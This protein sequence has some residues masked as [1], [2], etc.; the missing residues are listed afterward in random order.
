MTTAGPSRWRTFSV[1]CL[2]GLMVISDG[3]VVTVALASIKLDLAFSDV[4]LVWV[5]NAYLLTFSGFVLLGG[6]LADIFGQR[7]LFLLG[8][9]LFTAASAACGLADTRALLI[10]ARAVQGLGGAIVSSVSLSLTLS[11]FTQAPERAKAMGIYT[12]VSL[13]AGAF[14]LFVG[15]TLTSALG[16]R[17]IFWVN[18]PLGAAIYPFCRAS[19]PRQRDRRPTGKVDIAGAMVVT[20]S[21]VLAVYASINA[22]DAGW[23]SVQTLTLLAS[24][25][26]LLMLFLHIESRASAPLVPLGLLR[27]RNLVVGGAISMLWAFTV[28]GWCLVAAFYLQVVLKCNPEQVGLAFLPSNLSAAAISLGLSAR[29]VARFGIKR[30]LSIGLLLTAGALALLARAP[31]GG[32]VVIDV[33][34]AMLLDGIG[35]G[36]VFS[37][38]L[39]AATS[40]TLPAESGLVAGVVNTAG[41]ISSTL[42]L[43]I[44]V[45]T[46]AAHTRDLVT[47]GASLPA[48]L[49]SGYHRA[50]S[51]GAILLIVASLMTRLLRIE[52]H[53]MAHVV[54]IAVQ[55]SS[56]SI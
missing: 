30:T 56:A 26:G 39:L 19:L 34:P 55:D 17:W 12:F 1:L 2:A 54:D 33:L 13:F 35:S 36:L 44:L 22:N 45:A 11:L 14:G 51:I 15:G 21:S 9:S 52:Q 50:F 28:G 40:G 18:L 8:I 23:S 47:I 4:T 10:L 6:R 41:I 46:A 20:V 43:A 25:F 37:P 31:V 3:A 16:W 7:R 5:L 27:R 38:M 48:A 24:S 32:S 29:L 42:G 53:E 49:D